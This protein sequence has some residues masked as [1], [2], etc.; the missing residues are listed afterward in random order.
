MKATRWAVRP[1]EMHVV[2]ACSLYCGTSTTIFEKGATCGSLMVNFK[3][4]CGRS[5][6]RQGLAGR[7]GMFTS[8]PT[9]VQCKI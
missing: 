1:Q 4:T 6:S 5:K 8:F 9:P 3:A 2:N 7:R